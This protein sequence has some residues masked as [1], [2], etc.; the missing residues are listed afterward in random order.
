MRS[1]FA[2][3]LAATAG[4]QA[5]SGDVLDGIPIL[6]VSITSPLNLSS[7]PANT[8]SRFWLRPGTSQG[9]INY[10][11]PVF[12]ARGTEESAE[13]GR[14]LSLSASIHGDELN[15]I[16]VVHR[17]FQSLNESGVVTSGSFNGTIIGVP[18]LNPN[19]NFLNGRNFYT[20]GNS[21]FLTNLN[22]I[23]PGADDPLDA[24]L[25]DSYAGNIWYGLW[26]NGSNVDIAV[27]FHTLSTG[28]DGPLWAYADYRL[29]GVQELAELASPD[30]IK[31]D[32]G[33]PGSV[34]TT[35][36]DNGIPAI[37][38]EIGPAKRWN[39]DLIDRAEAFVYRILGNLAMISQNESIS[40]G[41]VESDLSATYKGTNFSSV[42]VTTT[43]WVNMTVGV[44]DD[45]EEGQEVG[46]VYGWFGDV[47]ETLTTTVAGRVLTVE[48]DPAVEKGKGVLDIVYNATDSGDESN[49]RKMKRSNMARR[50]VM[51]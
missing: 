27:D 48:V 30:V 25:T 2:L 42:A 47:I 35:F 18:Q 39:S 41:G 5:T 28:S 8:I 11:L 26:G 9:N 22:R 33:E 14:K 49:S 23:M 17:V 6:D 15:G 12:I 38:L 32:P 51:F 3:A 10:F 4:A 24:S 20:P 19:G 36:V 46:V 16:P 40:L 21:G 13:T 45:V 1:P 29:D 43:G 37:T 31:I 50:G 7:V 34:E 44:L